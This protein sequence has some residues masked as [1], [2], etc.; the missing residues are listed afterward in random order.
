MLRNGYGA[1]MYLH[2]KLLVSRLGQRRIFNQ[3]FLVFSLTTEIDSPRYRSIYPAYPSVPYGAF[4]ETTPRIPEILAAD[5]IPSTH[6][7]FFIF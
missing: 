6:K 4:P 2:T 5:T 3:S 7:L 1:T